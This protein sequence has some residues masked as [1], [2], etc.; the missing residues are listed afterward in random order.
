MLKA[1]LLTEFRKIDGLNLSTVK[2][3]ALV[4]FLATLPQILAKAV[5]PTHIENGFFRAG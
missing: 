2:M 5:T 1:H 4:D 3:N